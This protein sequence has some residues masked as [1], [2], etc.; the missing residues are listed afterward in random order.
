M[1][2]SQR[3]KPGTQVASLK[4]IGKSVY[5]WIGAN[6][7]SNAGAVGTSNGLLAIDAQQTKSLGYA[8]RRA[9]EDASGTT[10]NSIG[11]H[12]FSP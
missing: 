2:S 11:R 3:E 12:S 6:G 4:E 7:D 8:F 5:A 10:D 1:N 9:I